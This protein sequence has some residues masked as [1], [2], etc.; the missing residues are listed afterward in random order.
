MEIVTAYKDLN[1]ALH[2]EIA[3][4]KAS[5]K[6]ILKGQ[7]LQQ[8]VEDILLPLGGDAVV[9]HRKDLDNGDWIQH[10]PATVFAVAQDL[11]NLVKR[12]CPDSRKRLDKLEDH[13]GFVG[14]ANE[15]SFFFGRLYTAPVEHRPLEKAS[16][17]IG[18]IRSDGR[19]FN[20]PYFT[21][22]TESEIK[23]VCVWDNRCGA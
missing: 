2:T 1:G 12:E 23:G 13:H 11:M 14:I 16:Y 22:C 20:Q 19:E 21:H 5:D 4:C 9:K 7:I 15:L 8:D 18:H 10:E 17:I 3:S 6:A